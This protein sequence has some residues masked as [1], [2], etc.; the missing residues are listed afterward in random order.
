M[1]ITAPDNIHHRFPWVPLLLFLAVAAGIAA[2]GEFFYTRAAAEYKQQKAG[3]LAAIAKLKTGQITAWREERIADALHLARDPFFGRA[4]AEAASGA[5]GAAER[6][7]LLESSLKAFTDGYDFISAQ[8]LTTGGEVLAGVGESADAIGAHAL[9]QAADVIRNGGPVFSDLHRSANVSAAHLDLMVPVFAPEAGTKPAAILLL[10]LTP[11][12]YLYPLIQ[13]WPTPS[14][15]GETLLVRREG[16]KILFLNELRFRRDTV[17]SFTIPLADL[18]AATRAAPGEQGVYEERDYRGV[19]VMAAAMPVPGFGWTMVAKMD[20]A[21]LYAPLRRQARTVGIAAGMLI[22]TVAMLA[23][24]LWGRRED[25]FLRERGR[26]AMEREALAH[27]F[28]LV[29]QHANDIILLV[30]AQR[31]IL[32]ANDRALT[33]YGYSWDELRGMSLDELRPAAMRAELAGQLA[34][35]DKKGSLLYETMG[36]R[37][38]GS[39]F[40][41]EVGMHAF[42]SGGEKFYQAVIR[43]ISDRRQAE[44]ALQRERDQAKM[45]IDVA[46]VMIAVLDEN[47]TI[48]M[49]NRAG[50]RMLGCDDP[51]E[52]LGKNWYDAVVPQENREERRAQY[53]AELESVPAGA[54][55][56][57]PA[58][59]VP[60]RMRGGEERLIYFQDA[61]LRGRDGRPAGV[62]ASGI[63]VT[64]RKRAERRLERM[65]R[66]HA[67]LGEINEAVFRADNLDELF[68]KACAIAVE[69]GKF[70][71]A[72]FGLTDGPGGSIRPVAEA[73]F[74]EGYVEGVRAVASPDEPEG[75]GPTGQAARTRQCVTVNDIMVDPRF[76][77]WR[78]RALQ[79][80]YRSCAS[81]PLMNGEDVAGILSLYSSEPGFFGR[82]EIRVLDEIGADLAFAVE[83]IRRDE[84][85]RRTEFEHFRLAMVVEQ[86][87][88]GV[89]LTD[90]EGRMTYV[91]PAFERMSG[92]PREEALGRN[93][94]ILKSGRQPRAVYEEMWKT[95]LDGRPWQGQLVNRRKDGTLYDV[96]AVISPIRD[97]KGGIIGFVGTSYDVTRERQLE[98]QFLQSQKMESIGRLAGGVAHDFNNI[99][100]VITGFAGI[101]MDS[102]PPEDPRRGDV[103]EIKKAADKAADLTRQLLAFGRRQV[104]EFRTVDLNAAVSDT[105]RMLGRMIGE[106]IRL[107]LELA[108]DL[109][110]VRADSGQVAQI[111]MNLVVNARDAMPEGGTLT[112]STENLTLT[113]E[114]PRGFSGAGAGEYAAFSVADTGTGITEEV[115]SHLFEPFFT[116]KGLGKGMGL[117]TVYGIVQQ[118]GGDIRV[119]SEPGRGACFTV[120]LPL[121]KDGAE[122]P[123]AMP[124]APPSPAH[125]S[126]EHILLIE[127]EEAVRSLTERILRHNG[128][129]VSAAASGA[130]AVEIFRREHGQFALIL[131]DI[132]LGDRNGLDVVEELL[133]EKP[134]I[135]VILCSGYADDGSRD[136]LGRK[137]NFAFLRKP[138][139]QAVLAAAVR[140]SIDRKP[141]AP[142]E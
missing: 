73:G 7:R 93:P 32:E 114:Q 140:A 78:E 85:H 82:E 50:A 63:D 116:T 51:S 122:A 75:R 86:A 70:R 46:G 41:I 92:F 6:R 110:P 94:S 83:K 36:L 81:V 34:A 104:I 35:V 115:R 91:N 20:Q 30:D 109:K 130:E 139:R 15:S 25:R 113:P 135:P 28:D 21:E 84:V 68:R 124:A 65:D 53:R 141:A 125:G 4:A 119:R 105:A 27:H 112:I 72:W 108:P 67:M 87:A 69:T 60:I 49:I 1:T 97:E 66:L 90:M 52:L 12:H 39:A 117:A 62:I 98:R 23:I 88:E 121:S 55:L 19:P 142:Q 17:L 71:M 3:E 123:A 31:R 45:Y 133:K 37:R 18:P 102:L 129:T 10:R 120:C 134:D 44:E 76:E 56:P 2:A 89:I 61:V 40:P 59:A 106:D 95:L 107:V 101:V 43:D 103:K 79:R 47:A 13:S 126:G 100:Q 127:D 54:N 48:T 77:P 5:P 58:D 14:A 128:Y 111:I 16:D 132:V 26:M 138:Y 136:G 99:L 38:D 42:E 29:M 74:S 118:H 96:E 22:L 33:A 24:Y 11:V 64:D 131:S 57:P 137:N 8:L 80:G 9:D